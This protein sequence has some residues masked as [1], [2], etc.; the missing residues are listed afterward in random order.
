MS[1]LPPI[2]PRNCRTRPRPHHLRHVLAATVAAEV[3]L[4]AG[5]ARRGAGHQEPGARQTK[6]VKQL[7]AE[8]ASRSPARPSRTASAI[9]GRSSTSSAPACWAR[10]EVQEV[11]QVAWPRVEQ[12]ATAAARA[13]AALYSAAAEDRQTR[14]RRPARQDRSAGLLRA[15]QAAGRALRQ[16]GR[17]TGATLEKVGR[18]Q[19][20]A[21]WSWPI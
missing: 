11:H 13:G 18:H 1:A 21:A 7:K 10:A 12:T 17:R 14:H 4:A 5:R 2:R 19:A 3:R 15:G 20:R 6:A 16:A 8:P 9:F